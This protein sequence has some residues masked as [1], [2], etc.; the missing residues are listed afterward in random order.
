M[1]S[2]ERE[3]YKGKNSFIIGMQYDL[4]ISPVSEKR[5]LAHQR[6]SGLT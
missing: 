5:N 2:R 3:Y 1:S 4:Q 6:A